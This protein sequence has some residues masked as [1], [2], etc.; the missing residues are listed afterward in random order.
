[1]FTLFVIAHPVRFFIMTHLRRQLLILVK[2][3]R[4]HLLVSSISAAWHT[5]VRIEIP[6]SQ[7]RVMAES[8][9]FQNVLLCVCN[10]EKR[11]YS[12][13]WYEYYR[14]SFA[15]K[16]FYEQFEIRKWTAWSVFNAKQYDNAVNFTQFRASVLDHA[17]LIFLRR[18]NFIPSRKFFFTV[19][20]IIALSKGT[21]HWLGE[22]LTEIGSNKLLNCWS[23]LHILLLWSGFPGKSKP[24][25]LLFTA[26]VIL[27][28]YNLLRFSP[29][30][31]F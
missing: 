8:E 30:R 21:Y 5:H 25:M 27:G 4:L 10:P 18:W 14:K 3:V 9:R 7:F 15:K 26:V 12:K 17:L 13:Y 22:T 11:L 20:G 29:I 23:M 31:A 24:I 2:P 19:L 1:M 16:S 28:E 6:K